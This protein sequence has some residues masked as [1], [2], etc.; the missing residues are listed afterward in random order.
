MKIYRYFLLA[1][2][3]IIIDQTSKLLVHQNMF[4]HQEITVL[5]I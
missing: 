5:G 3:V 1:L 2:L 4:L